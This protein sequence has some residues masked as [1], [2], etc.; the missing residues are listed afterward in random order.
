MLNFQQLSKAEQ[1]GDKL[2]ASLT[3]DERFIVAK[4]ADM[5]IPKLIGMG[6]KHDATS[7]DL[8]RMGIMLGIS[9]GVKIDIQN[10][11][12]IGR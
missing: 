10:S 11:Q 5:A 3:D 4:Y 2:L 6:T 1:S 8:I 9:L 12:V 7:L